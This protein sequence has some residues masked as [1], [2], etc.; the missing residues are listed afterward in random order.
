MFAKNA[1]RLSIHAHNATNN[2]ARSNRKRRDQM[3]MKNIHEIL[4][5]VIAISS[6]ILISGCQTPGKVVSTETSKVCP[7]CKTE[8]VTT[9]IQGLTYKKH[10]CPFCKDV[11]TDD[12]A[13]S[14]AMATYTSRDI[15]T[16]HIC[17]N[18]KS[19]VEPCSACRN[20]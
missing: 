14:S 13:A 1:A 3:K 10:T 15:E 7:T 19:I 11:V 4:T 6:L 5:I 16:V 20:L 9:P 12:S 8:T 2:K 18:C 17:N